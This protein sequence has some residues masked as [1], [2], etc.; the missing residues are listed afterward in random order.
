MGAYPSVYNVNEHID[1][2][3]E[4]LTSLEGID[5]NGDGIISKDEM[6][7]FM[8]KQQDEMDKFKNDMNMHVAD[9]NRELDAAKKMIEVQSKKI[10]DLEKKNSELTLLCHNTSGTN[11]QNARLDLKELSKDR[12]DIIVDD[13]LK[14]EDINIKYFP[15]WVEKKLYTNV[16]TI[17]VGI[18]ENI[19]EDAS[20]NFLGHQI[21]FQLKPEQ[22]EDDINIIEDPIKYK[23]K[24][25]KPF[26]I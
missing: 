18:I 7:V 21:S 14:N 10:R 26:Q 3:K 6:E 13:L 8:R 5:R 23:K 9:K 25:F 20:I 17:L 1:E 2:I 4:R 12:I 15:D 22:K 24:L 11:M 16:F 19:L